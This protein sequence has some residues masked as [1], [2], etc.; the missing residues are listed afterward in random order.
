[1]HLN[2]YSTDS[3]GSVFDRLDCNLVGLNINCDIFPPDRSQASPE[4]LVC[5]DN[6]TLQCEIVHFRFVFLS[7]LSV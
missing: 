4:R 1:M 7:P 3:F 2:L 5:V 6:K